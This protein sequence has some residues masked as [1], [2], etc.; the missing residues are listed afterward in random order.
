MLPSSFIAIALKQFTVG[1]LLIGFCRVKFN[2]TSWEKR[3]VSPW[4]LKVF[5]PTCAV[6]KS[7]FLSV[8]RTFQNMLV[9]KLDK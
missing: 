9:F 7:F 3:T 1:E 2:I 8:I 4:S 6:T 5:N